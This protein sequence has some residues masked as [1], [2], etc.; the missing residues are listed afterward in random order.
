M[1]CGVAKD[2]FEAKQ[3]VT[4]FADHRN[5]AYRVNLATLNHF[6]NTHYF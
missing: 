5:M 2:A 4:A 3:L 1:A 6:N